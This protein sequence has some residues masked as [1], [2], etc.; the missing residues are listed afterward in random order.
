MIGHVDPAALGD[1]FVRLAERGGLFAMATTLV[2]I[3]AAFLLAAGMQV[4]GA[5]D[6]LIGRLLAAAQT[7]FRLIAA[8]MAAGVTMIAVTSH[9]GVTALVIGGLFRDAYD[10]MGLARENLSRSLEDAVTITEPLMPWTVS[11]V[12][13]A[14]TLGVPTVVYGPWAVFCYAG[15]CVSL[16]IAALYR[17]TG[18][19]IRRGEGAKPDSDPSDWRAGGS[20]NPDPADGV[21]P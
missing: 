4:S 15:P 19:G 16:V 12:F 6:L 14:G 21:L 2:V 10:R 3:L 20:R 18:Y 9:Q 13:M 1:P 5:L 8:T 17:R 11:G 7:V